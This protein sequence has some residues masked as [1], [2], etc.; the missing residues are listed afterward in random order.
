[1]DKKKQRERKRRATK[2]ESWWRD[3][4]EVLNSPEETSCCSSSSSNSNEKGNKGKV[5]P[6]TFGEIHE[7]DGLA[8]AMIRVAAGTGP[9]EDVTRL[10]LVIDSSKTCVEGVWEEMPRLHTLV[11]DGSRLVSFRDLGVGLRHLSTLSL[12]YSG[13]E[14]LDGIGALSGLRKLQLAHNRVSDV[15]PL[16]CHRNLHALGLTQNRISEVNVLDILSTL[17]MLCR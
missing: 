4:Q 9:L 17:P 8:G 13:V 6:I 1:M 10:A 3:R 15:T 16:A 5:K 14:D 2:T 11:L 12:E 7:E